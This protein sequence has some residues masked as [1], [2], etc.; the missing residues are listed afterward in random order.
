MGK[1]ERKIK[2]KR[3]GE[4][5][6]AGV[7]PEPLPPAVRSGGSEILA[8]YAQAEATIMEDVRPRKSRA[9]KGV[10]RVNER[11]ILV[12]QWIAEQL[13]VNTSQLG[14]L[15]ARNSERKDAIKSG[16]VSE[17]GVMNVARRWKD[18]GWVE[19]QRPYVKK[20]G[21]VWLTS[22]GISDLGL[23]FRATTPSLYTLRHM[24]SVNQVRLW[25]ERPNN[26]KPID[27][28]IPERIIRQE[29]QDHIP[30]AIV[31]TGGHRVAIEVE[32]TQKASS[33]FEDI[34][35]H[36]ESNFDGV[37]YFVS[38]ESERIIREVVK[39]KPRFFVRNLNDLA[40]Y[41]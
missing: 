13:C 23:D 29:K 40:A 9:D 1:G 11:D 4:E 21:Y 5:D 15:L 28:W 27:Q 36:L 19:T 16:K 14:I 31:V 18:A 35:P 3:L 6:A 22:K 30:D 8:S 12:L 10:I 32:L 38:D 34:I 33:R 20:P 26:D 24:D 41:G 7:F 37:W 25:L 2:D 39:G 17:S